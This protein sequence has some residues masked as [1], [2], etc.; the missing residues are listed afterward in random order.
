MGPEIELEAVAQCFVRDL[1]DPALPGRTGV[2]NN[3]ID[4]TERG[5]HLV[6]GGAHLLRIGH[7]TGNSQPAQWSGDIFSG[8]QI[9]IENAYFCAFAGKSAGRR[10]TNS[11]PTTGY[12][13]DPSGQRFLGTGCQ[14]GLFQ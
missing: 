13:A 4:A 12:H 10:R 9:P 6:K 1:A 14:L 7:I 2:G 3:N 11:R 5:G 8:F